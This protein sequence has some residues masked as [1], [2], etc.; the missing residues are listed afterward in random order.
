MISNCID[1]LFAGPK[2][3]KNEK[4]NCKSKGFVINFG[5]NNDTTIF[6]TK[7]L[8]SLLNISYADNFCLEQTIFNFI[9]FTNIC[10]YEN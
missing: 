5:R 10:K 2:I 8:S 3:Y 9:E 6:C 4:L 1:L 7:S